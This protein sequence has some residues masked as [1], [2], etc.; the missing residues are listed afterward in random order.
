MKTFCDGPHEGSG[1]PLFMVIKSE[2]SV[3]YHLA[4][5][6]NKHTHTHTHTPPPTPHTPISKYHT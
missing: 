1:S 6:A 4:E 2:F 5:N 3:L